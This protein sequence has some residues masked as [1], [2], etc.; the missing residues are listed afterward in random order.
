MKRRP[1]FS[2]VEVLIGVGLLASVGMTGATLMS[3]GSGNAARAADA[4][5]ATTIAARAVDRLQALGFAALAQK[6][7]PP[8]DEDLSFVNDPA[9]PPPARIEPL[10][11]DGAFYTAREQ[12]T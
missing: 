8:R 12:I 6:V 9:A 2:L 5:E 11:H 7:G 1:A 3:A 10:E 4:M